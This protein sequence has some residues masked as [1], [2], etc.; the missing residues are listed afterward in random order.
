M[1]LNGY[2]D[3]SDIY[4]IAF[5]TKTFERKAFA[6]LPKSEKVSDLC[7]DESKEVLFVK[8]EECIY[9]VPLVER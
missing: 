4:I 6:F 9:K 1:A 3:E 7:L 2:Y 5:N 8:S